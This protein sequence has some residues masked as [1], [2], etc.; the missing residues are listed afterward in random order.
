VSRNGQVEGCG[1][2]ETMGYT[3]TQVYKT[4]THK[5]FHKKIHA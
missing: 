3:N 5:L 1:V 2:R 4:H